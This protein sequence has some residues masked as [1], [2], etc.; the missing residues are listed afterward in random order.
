M[1]EKKEERGDDDSGDDGDNEIDEQWMSDC[2]EKHRGI[3]Q[4]E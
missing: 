4:K 1:N 2:D 3:D